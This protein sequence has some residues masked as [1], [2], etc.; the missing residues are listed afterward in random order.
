MYLTQQNEV[1][2]LVPLFR[3]EWGISTGG[4]GF[5]S[6]YVTLVSNKRL[7]IGFARIHDKFSTTIRER[8]TICGTPPK[9]LVRL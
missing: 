7:I 8:A 3:S 5:F 9:H 6:S 1:V 2:V 4:G